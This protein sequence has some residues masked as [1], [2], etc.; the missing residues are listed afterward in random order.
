MTRCGQ[1][2]TEKTRMRSCFF[3]SERASQ[4]TSA[5]FASSLG[6]KVTGPSWIQRRAPPAAWPRPGT[7]TSAS[8]RSETST[9]GTASASR[10]R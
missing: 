7:C 4:R 5:I 9:S 8:R 10:R 2:P 6:W 3:A 1:E